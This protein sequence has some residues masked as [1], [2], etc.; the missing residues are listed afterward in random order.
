MGGYSLPILKGVSLEVAK[1]E[2]VAIM[3]P[4]GSGKTSLLN[5]ISGIDSQDSGEIF[6]KGV[7]INTKS[8]EEMTSF[9]RK[10]IGFVFQFFNLIPA[11]TVI[12][13]VLLPFL[14]DD[15]RRGFDNLPAVKEI[16][17]RLGLAG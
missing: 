1:G 4:S 6:F 5:C 13:N 15:P 16:L 9:R 10:N 3:G 12:E 2:V 11:L 14:V 8:E 7:E 17:A